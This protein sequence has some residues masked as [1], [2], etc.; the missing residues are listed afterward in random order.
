MPI[1]SENGGWNPPPALRPTG[2]FVTDLD[3]TL[4]RSDRT[5]A[6]ADLAALRRLGECGVVRVLATG[7]SLFSF[8]KVRTPDLPLDYLVF[9]TGAGLAE[10]PSGRIVRAQSLDPAEVRRACEVLRALGLDFMVQ[11]PIPETHAFGFHCERPPQPGLRPAHRALRALRLPARR[12]RGRL[13]PGHPAG[14]DRAAG[15]PPGDAAR[16]APAAPGAHRHP[17]DLAAGP[18]LDL[19]RDLPGHRLEEPHHR[20]ARRPARH[21][22]GAHR[23]GRQRLQRPRPARLVRSPLRHRQRP[24]RPARPLPGRR[25]ARRVPG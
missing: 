17:L 11:R 7:R 14:R 22:P 13:R 12:R 24:A 5:F 8:E 21:P 4:L 23:R 16:G 6:A 9:S 15:R 1:I 10:L 19:D 2:L 20:L 3:G 18:P 25:L